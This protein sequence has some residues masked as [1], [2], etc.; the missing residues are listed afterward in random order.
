MLEALGIAARGRWDACLE[1]YQKAVGIPVAAG[2]DAAAAKKPSADAWR[3]LVWRSRASNTPE[4]LAELIRDE[5]TAADELPKLMRAFDFQAE[6]ATKNDVLAALAFGPALATPEATAFVR[7][8]AIARLKNFDPNK[9]PEYKQQ[10][11]EIV[12]AAYGTPQFVAMVKQFNLT[13]RFD[14]LVKMAIEQSGTQNAAD[15]V[16][17]L[18]EAKKP[19]HDA[20]RAG[21]SIDESATKLLESI[22][23]AGA[24][25]TT[26]VV[27]PLID[28]EDRPM[29]LRRLAIEALS[30]SGWGAEELVKRAE[31]STLP[32][33]LTQTATAAMQQ[34]RYGHLGNRIAKA[35]PSPAGK[36]ARPIPPIRDLVKQ[37]GDA[38]KGRVVFN[39]NGTCSKCHVVAGIGKELGPALDEIGSKLSREAMFV[40][41]LYPSAGVS[42]NYETFTVV[43]VDGDVFTG[44]KQSETDAEVTIKTVEGLVK[45]IAKDDIEIFE[46]QDISIMPADLQKVMTNQEIVDLVDYLQTLKKK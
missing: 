25:R 12:D 42:H 6:S 26:P 11:S 27:L 45:K 43:T 13:D 32:D 3:Q 2:D 21:L 22:R 29:A 44:L 38:K 36:D 20:L 46:K 18:A 34:V 23:L 30:K 7:G 41:I 16:T 40:S 9:N 19:G 39:T 33:A 35:F 31:A 15:A 5:K 8:E 1:A 24:S 17:T 37:T 14:D 10:L 28:D 4:L